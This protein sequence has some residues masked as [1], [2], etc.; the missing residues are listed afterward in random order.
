MGMVVVKIRTDSAER[1]N[2]RLWLFAVKKK[3]PQISAFNGDDIKSFFLTSF[4]LEICVFRLSN[5]ICLSSSVEYYH[6]GRWIV[7]IFWYWKK[8]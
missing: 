7:I 6:R 1:E 3:N 8:H 2:K 5:N 4:F